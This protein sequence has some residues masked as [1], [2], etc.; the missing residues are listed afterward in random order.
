[1]NPRMN[2]TN[3]VLDTANHNSINK[4]SPSIQDGARSRHNQ[5]PVHL[6][7]PAVV[8]VMDPR[9]IPVISI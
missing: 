7:S 1:M 6:H 4:F 9:S 8:W 2:I 3:I 5:L